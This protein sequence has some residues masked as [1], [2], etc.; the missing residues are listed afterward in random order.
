MTKRQSTKAS[1]NMM[2]V[3]YTM[4]GLALLERAAFVAGQGENNC[5]CSDPSDDPNIITLAGIFDLTAYSWGRD[6]FDVTVQLL[7]QG[8]WGILNVTIGPKIKYYMRDTQCDEITAT[9]KYWDV[10]TE[11][12]NRPPQG[13]VGCRCSG[14]SM[15]LAKVSG[16]E[17]VPHVSQASNSI[18]LSDAQKYPYFS[19]LVPPSDGRGE[20]KSDAFDLYFVVKLCRFS[21]HLSDGPEF[22]ARSPTSRS[23]G[24]YDAP[25]WVA[26]CDNL[27]HRFT[28]RTRL[29]DRIS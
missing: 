16:L 8:H 4:I 6:V 7:H 28:L 1:S 19:R 20:G 2:L 14:A 3:L 5:S 11:N 17:K 9:R 29:G 12:G 27:G 18:L 15:G 25:L 10:R 23:L 26:T 24:H 13:I 22:S 21:T